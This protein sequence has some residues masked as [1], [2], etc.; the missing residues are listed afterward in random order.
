MHFTTIISNLDGDYFQDLLRA[1]P[2]KPRETLFARFGIPRSKKKVSTLLPNRDPARAAKL[3]AAFTQVEEDD[4]EG[5]QL[6]E[7]V[8]RLYLL[9]HRQILSEAMDHLGV[10]H[11]EGLTEEDVDFAGMKEGEREAL[12]AALIQGHEA[13]DVDLYLAYMDASG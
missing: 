2:R 4:E 11:E 10:S 12:R 6:A 1:C 13:R 7:E 8:I 9:K 3:Q 5:Q